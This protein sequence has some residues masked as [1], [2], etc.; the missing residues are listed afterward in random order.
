MK[1]TIRLAMQ[2]AEMRAP[3]A[4][5]ELCLMPACTSVRLQEQ[6]HTAYRKALRNGILTRPPHCSHCGSNRLIEGHH[7]D[8]TLPLSVIWLCR[9]CHQ[10]GHGNGKRARHKAETGIGAI[11]AGKVGL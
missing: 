4:R 2:Q 11:D 3:Q 7:E 8:Y 6:C 1:A 10:S 5:D 9:A